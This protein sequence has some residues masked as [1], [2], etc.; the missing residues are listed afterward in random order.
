MSVCLSLCLCPCLSACLCF[1]LSVHVSVYLSMCL[2]VLQSGSVAGFCVD[3]VLYPLDTVKT[4]LQ[5]SV[6]LSVCQS[7]CLSIYLSVCLSV[8]ICLCVCV[9]CSLALWLVSVLMLFYIHWILSRPGF[10][11]P[12]ASFTPVVSV[13][14]TGDLDLWL[15]ALY[16]EVTSFMCC[17]RWHHISTIHSIHSRV[18]KPQPGG[19]YWVLVFLVGLQPCF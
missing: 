10:K 14:S 11:V 15:L 3:V 19:F 5:S 6:C 7:V 17:T 13:A 4:R 9:C 2:C 12:S 1:S 18:Q 8:S 16:P